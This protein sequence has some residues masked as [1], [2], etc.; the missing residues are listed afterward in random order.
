MRHVEDLSPT[1]RDDRE[2]VMPRQAPVIWGDGRSD[3][4]HARGR[5]QFDTFAENGFLVVPDV[6]DPD[7]VAAEGRVI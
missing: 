5:P 7:E 4:P 2:R 1:R 3:R 6:F